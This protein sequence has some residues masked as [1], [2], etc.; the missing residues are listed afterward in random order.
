MDPLPDDPRSC[1]AISTAIAVGCYMTSL[2]QKWRGACADRT[3]LSPEC[4]DSGKSEISRYQY[5]AVSSCIANRGCRLSRQRRNPYL[6]LQRHKQPCRV[7]LR[8][9]E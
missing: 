6:L 5:L 7:L 4:P 1:P 3:W 8:D 9:L 2:L